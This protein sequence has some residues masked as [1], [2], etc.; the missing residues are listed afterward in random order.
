MLHNSAYNI[1]PVI[2]T[3]LQ[4]TAVTAAKLEQ[5]TDILLQSTPAAT[6]YSIGR[7]KVL[8]YYGP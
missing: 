2:T 8:I 1:A 7:K 3:V 6:M 5:H 4:M